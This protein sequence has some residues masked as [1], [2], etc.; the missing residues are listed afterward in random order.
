MR[1]SSRAE[2]EFMFN[3]KLKRIVASFAVMLAILLTALG[4][5]F[6]VAKAIN[7]EED[8]T[9]TYSKNRSAVKVLDEVV[10]GEPKYFKQ[11]AKTTELAATDI[12]AVMNRI[13]DVADGYSAVV[14]QQK[15]VLKAGGTVFEKANAL[16]KS[17]VALSDELSNLYE[18]SLKLTEANYLNY[19]E[20][21][22][23]TTQLKGISASFTVLGE[24]VALTNELYDLLSVNETAQD[25]SANTAYGYYDTDL[26]VSDY[27]MFKLGTCYNKGL[28]AIENAEDPAA[29]R[30]EY[31]DQLNNVPRNVFEHIYNEYLAVTAVERTE[32]TAEEADLANNGLYNKMGEA[33]TKVENFWQ[34]ASE[35]VKSAY[36]T[37]YD[38]LQKYFAGHQE[39]DGTAV[40]KNSSSLTYAINGTTIMTIKAY[41]KN[42]YVSGARTNKEATVFAPNASISLNTATLSGAERNVGNLITEKNDKLEAGYLVRFNVYGGTTMSQAFDTEAVNK[43]TVGGVIYVINFNLKKYQEELVGKDRGLLGGVIGNTFLK[44]VW[45]SSDKAENVKKASELIADTDTDLCYMYANGELVPFEN[46]TYDP[47][48]GTLMLETTT[49]GNFAVASAQQTG[50]FWTQPLFWILVAVGVV[51][52]II[53]IRIIRRFCKYSVKFYSNGGSKV[54]KARARKGQYFVM[55][56]NPVRKGFVFAGWYA[57]K[58][59]K[60]RFVQTRIVKRKNLKAYAKWSLE[61][62]PDRINRY[63]ANLRNALASHGALP[64][65][66]ELAEGETKTFA[67]IEKGEKEIKLYFALDVAELQ[68][69]GYKAV[70]APAGYEETPAMFTIATREDFLAAQKL[71]AKL[72]EDNNLGEVQYEEAK[73]EE[74]KFT[75]AL[76]LPVVEVVTEEPAALPVVEP[77][78]PEE[79]TT[80]EVVTEEPAEESVEEPVEEPTEEVA[81]EPVTDEKLIEYFTKIRNAVCG[82]ALYEMNDK[83]EDGKMLIKLYKKEEAVYCYMA[84]DPESY[85]LETVSLGFGDTPALLKIANDEDLEKAIALVEVI[86][87]DHGFEKSDEPVEEKPYEGK[88]FGYRIHFVEE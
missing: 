5:G 58:A 87:L 42:G 3:V 65:G 64:E 21:N 49:F 24:K 33:Q 54:K 19:D 53:I 6:T 31:V 57:D 48:G 44:G 88:G 38:Y 43:K 41:I 10:D 2:G 25:K 1:L 74:V 76:C 26:S 34:G 62:S 9:I 60:N 68:K 85:G 63:Y 75:L 13:V 46:I 15:A 7:A 81:E 72:I 27:G 51:L 39:Y 47:N 80:E 30:K 50:D 35:D 78:E 8:V 28:S 70:A 32:L 59:L 77:V 73:E 14:S 45:G 61:L 18:S 36:A 84:L 66:Y 86:M 40:S 56:A 55:P 82:Y 71:V 4:S 52:L 67:V 83:A 29:A 23:F 11:L 16:L 69:A 79:E 17:H 22:T 37:K 12:L 20:G